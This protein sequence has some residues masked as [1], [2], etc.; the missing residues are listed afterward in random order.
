MTASSEHHDQNTYHK[1]TQRARAFTVMTAALLLLLQRLRPSTPKLIPCKPGVM[2][3]LYMTVKV[4]ACDE[5]GQTGGSPCGVGPLPGHD[6]LGVVLGRS[7]R[8]V[9]AKVEELRS[10][11]QASAQQ[12]D[13]H[14]LVR[15]TRDLNSAHHQ[16]QDNH[17][18][19][20]EV[21]LDELASPGKQP[22]VP[23]MEVWILFQ[24]ACVCVVLM[25]CSLHRVI[26]QP[27]IQGASQ[28]PHKLIELGIGWCDCTMHGIMS[29]NEDPAHQKPVSQ[30]TTTI[31][32]CFLWNFT[33]PVATYEHTV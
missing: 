12:K 28:A 17:L 23:S 20:G 3:V 8:N 9:C 16:I 6:L 26:V 4:I 24:N 27:S 30:Y 19:D 21:L 5:A 32:R 18:L 15:R 25:M 7:V 1:S 10:A 33:Y 31:K 14:V 29:G 13:D 11:A 22:R 2:M